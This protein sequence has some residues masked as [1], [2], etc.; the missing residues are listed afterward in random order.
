MRTDDKINN[1]PAPGLP[2]LPRLSF[3]PLFL[4]L[5]PAPCPKQCREMRKRDCSQFIT[6]CLCQYFLLTLFPLSSVGCLL[7]V[8]S[9]RKRLLQCGCNSSCQKTYSCLGFSPW[10]AS[11]ARSLLQRGISMGCGFRQVIPPAAALVLPR[12]AVWI[13]P[14]A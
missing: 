9:F 7:G 13:S 10:A 5:L 3:T 4:T 12:A 6:L 14:T 8:Q 11:P 1:S 2:L